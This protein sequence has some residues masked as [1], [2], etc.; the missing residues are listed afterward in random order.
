M[1]KA[2]GNIRWS[3]KHEFRT[4]NPQH[5]DYRHQLPRV[6]GG[7]Y[8]VGGLTSKCSGVKQWQY[9]NVTAKSFKI[10]GIRMNATSI[11]SRKQ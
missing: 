8:M 7:G 11:I 9:E 3:W 2:R 1:L 6:L 4:K 5:D 10:Q